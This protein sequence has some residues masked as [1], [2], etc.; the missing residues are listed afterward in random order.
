MTFYKNQ[1][2]K[3]KIRIGI[4][5]FVLFC[6][7]VCALALPYLIG[8]LVSVGIQ[9]KGISGECPEVVTER[10]MEIFH[11]VLPEEEKDIYTS[12]YQLNDGAF[13][14]KDTANINEAAD[15]YENGVMS[16]FYFALNEAGGNIS[17]IDNKTV[18]SMMNLVTVDY[19]YGK[20][21]RIDTL[22]ETEKMA[23][24]KTALEAPKALKNQLAGFALPYFYEDAG[25]SLEDSQSDYIIRTGILMAFCAVLQVFCLI[26]VG[27]TSAKVSSQIECEVREEFLLHTSYF[28]RKER[29][30]L[31]DDLYAVFSDDIGNVGRITDFLLTS[32]MYAPI[33]SIGGIALSFSISPLLSVIV[34]FTVFVAVALIFAIYKRALPK[35]ENLQRAYGFL[36]R[37]AK[38]NISQIYTIRT[39]QTENFE[40]MR[41]MNVADN[42]RKNERYVLRSVFTGLSL[43]SLISNIIT[44]VAVI[45]SGNSLLSSNLVIGD[46]IAFLQYSVVTTAAITTL[47]SVILF[48]P[49]AKTS[50]EKISSI[51]AV[52][53]NRGE[54]GG[55][56]F[57]DK[58]TEKIEFRNVSLAGEN[59]LKDISFTVKKGE[60]TAIVGPTGCGKTTLLFLLTGDSEKESGEIYF[61]ET[62]IEKININALRKKISYAYSDPVIFS[63]TLKENMLL[64]GAD[65]EKSMESACVGACVDFID[66]M[67]TMLHNGANRYS[68]GQRSRIALAC[69]LSKKAEV[70]IIDDCLK[71]IDARTE[72]HILDYL[73]KIKED[74]AV[75]L[76]SQR[77]NSLMC[78]DKIIVLSQNGIEATGTHSELLN[79]SQ[80]YRE[81]A[82]LQGLE[83]SQNE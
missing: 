20:I 54:I 42:V 15:I 45:V 36:I 35:Y 64:Y 33:V 8:E 63:K 82:V 18:N 62:P 49:R 40:K 66:N 39:M 57:T 59:A 80:F 70:Y 19:L 81:L 55:E 67:D 79:A 61:D 46:V 6:Q 31:K 10:A 60:I 53:V 71:T 30:L 77:I 16:G 23:S 47:A 5:A 69:A 68:G 52:P 38:S 32:V 9:Q 22:T 7:A 34:L 1:L 14:L 56:T 27:R 73:A 37:F 3:Q 41:F 43:I 65:D 17:D 24:Y 26:V 44:A 21:K 12:F 4:C 51:M 50:F 13:Y 75:I 78:A 25:V 48:A 2:K 28:S 58:K 76:V 11:L 83:V 72:E 29:R 74:S